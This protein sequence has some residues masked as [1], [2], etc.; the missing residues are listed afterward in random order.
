MALSGVRSSWL[1]AARNSDFARLA[2]AASC[3][4]RRA[5]SC[6]R[7]RSAI[8]DRGAEQEK[9]RRDDRHE[10]L[11]GEQSLVQRRLHEGP[12]SEHC[13][14]DGD[15][16]YAERRRQ[17]AALAKAQRRPNERRENQVRQVE[18]RGDS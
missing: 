13:T 11:K 2:F 10:D 6:A 1:I 8:V 15:R 4:A 12:T 5:S 18:G 17:R 14:G 7:R 16:R 9:R 3:C